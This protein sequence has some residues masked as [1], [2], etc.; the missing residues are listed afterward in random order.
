[1]AATSL[2]HQATFS[3]AFSARD[4]DDLVAVLLRRPDLATPPPTSLLA[5]AA[6]ASSRSSLE[7]ALTSVT[8]LQ[9]SALEAL[10]VLDGSI[11]R[12][13]DLLHALCAGEATGEDRT[14]I[15]DAIAD[16]EQL[17]L[18]WSPT[19]AGPLRP[20]PGLAEILGPFP[21]G[22]GPATPPAQR[23]TA[24]SPADVDA[25][26]M[27]APAGARA[28][29]DA[30]T[31]GPPV[32]IIPRTDATGAQATSWLVDQGLLRRSDERHV[33][34]P[35]EV[36]LVLRAGRTHRDVRTTAPVPAAPTRRTEI[37][38]AEAGR[39]GLEA[40]RMVARLVASWEDAPP[41]VLRSGGLG[42]R[43][44]RRLADD[45]ETND[46]TAAVVV[47]IAAAAGLIADDGGTPA[48]FRPTQ[49]AP[50]WL[51]AGIAQRWA[52]LAR[53]WWTTRRMPW[54]VG[55][56]DE[57]G[58]LRAP[59]EPDLARPWV[60]RLRTAALGVLADQ[61]SALSVEQVL[62]VLAWHKPRAV[63]PAQA[64]AGLFAEAAWLG[65]TGAGALSGPGR[66]LTTGA[67]GLDSAFDGVLPQ[68]VA[69]L[70]IQGDLTGIVP[71]RPSRTL[72]GLLES[73]AEVESRGAATTV[74]FSA[75]SI[76]R[77][78][79]QGQSVEG[80][81]AE[82]TRY[83]RTPIPQ[84]LDYLVRDA[85]RRHGQL[86]AGAA[87]GYL[88]AED[89]AVLAELVTR[90]ELRPLG[91]TL[92]APTVAVAEAPA[93]EL[94][95]ALHEL[96]IGSVIEGPDGRTVPL[97]SAGERRERGR[98]PLRAPSPADDATVAPDIRRRQ[99][100]TLVTD[101]RRRAAEP[102][103]VART[104]PA[105]NPVAAADQPAVMG[106]PTASTSAPASAGVDALPPTTTPQQAGTSDPVAA[107]GLLREAMADNA[108]VWV[109]LVGPD[110][111]PVRRHVRPL[112]VD[113]GR[114]RALDPARDAE[115]TVA[116]HRIATVT[117]ETSPDR[118]GER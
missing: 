83:S 27:N 67:P 97:T 96:G 33:V 88:R 48:A 110:G 70:L 34:L 45:M 75:A 17:A 118:S 13:D 20:S 18:A 69:E 89:P 72:E 41:A 79:D 114:L 73:C 32:G 104:P 85:G 90:A 86:R 61:G 52:L 100:G 4:D 39:A 64:V 102:P 115:L 60:P 82:L 116:V 94:H 65:V 6:R 55:S 15:R 71:G 68:E 62:E 8:S 59:L 57:R 40:V 95:A 87:M 107:L 99:F 11:E 54:L 14:R 51:T 63:P 108:M 21:A 42:V 113:A 101:L 112:R 35:R 38:D 47:E 106:P 12:V 49:E 91:L 109:E 24:W 31:W 76:G 10:V 22:L 80:L 26:L 74:R 46:K 81:L 66:V 77:A 43:D 2:P 56:R 5:M 84:P 36:G 3:E 103:L 78:I 37:V 44:L 50:D 1:M 19:P 29:L 111:V 16:L 25:A 30:L 7:R 9:L 98:P 58:L 105:S 28:I 23:T 53:A 93:A 117:R 92:L